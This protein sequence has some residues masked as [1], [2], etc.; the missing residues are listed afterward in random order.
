M[1]KSLDKI[2]YNLRENHTLLSLAKRVSLDP[3]NSNSNTT[4]NELASLL[5]IIEEKVSSC[6]SDLEKLADL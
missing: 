6:I 5:N 3:Q 1:E 2:I 4:L